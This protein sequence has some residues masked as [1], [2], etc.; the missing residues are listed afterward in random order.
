[1][2]TNK[3]KASATSA[4]R[5]SKRARTSKGKGSKGGKAKPADDGTPRPARFSKVSA[6]AN[7]WQEWRRYTKNADHAY[8]YMLL[9]YLPHEDPGYDA[10]DDGKQDDGPQMSEGE[11]PPEGGR[12]P[13]CAR[14]KACMCFKPIEKRPNHE[15]R[16]SR[17]AYKLLGYQVTL[18]S[19]R[20]PDCFGMY[21][22]NR[23]DVYDDHEAYGLREV[24]EG[25]LVDFNESNDDDW[26]ERW[27]LC[28][29]AV[30]FLTVDHSSEMFLCVFA[31]CRFPFFAPLLV[32]FSPAL[33]PC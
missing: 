18:A 28:E 16:V 13:R 10:W 23:R 2:A 7:T 19:F 6:T 27:A 1:M 25:L 31:N 12:R 11:E 8:G 24:V 22:T 33:S 29:A 21:T 30:L 17:A 15:V 26:R 32:I 14:R 5:R 20:T 9:C 4:S 3:R